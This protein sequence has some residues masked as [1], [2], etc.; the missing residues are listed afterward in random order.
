MRDKLI[1]LGAE[2]SGLP[3]LLHGESIE[4]IMAWRVRGLRDEGRL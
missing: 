2:P 1:Q 4:D 3:P